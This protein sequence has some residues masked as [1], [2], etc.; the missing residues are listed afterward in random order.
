MDQT[1]PKSDSVF[2]IIPDNLVTNRRQARRR[3][4]KDS[5]VRVQSFRGALGMRRNSIVLLAILCWSLLGMSQT[6]DELVNKNIQAKGGMD[7]M[8]AIKTVRMT[9]KIEGP[10]LPPGRVSQENM[11]PKL[12]RETFSIQGMTAVQAYDGSTGWQIQPFGGKKD[13]MLM[14]DDDMR[15]LL[16]DADFDGP[17]VDYQEKGNRVEYLG[18]DVV[19]GDDALRLKVT[20]KNGDIVYY[21]LDP[22]TYLEIRKE[23]QEFIRG[24]IRENVIDLGSYKQAGGVMFPFS[25][26]SGPKNDPS[27]WQYVTYEKIEVNVPLET[28]EFAVP[29]SLK[30]EAPQKQETAK[31]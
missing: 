9:G 18:H 15:D 24:S 30:K 17:L 13:P 10:S 16:I 21:Y 14:G 28:S 6:A 26:A 7:K 3:D 25:V 12:V 27:S 4:V 23:T 22:D 2:V 1:S 5:F 31:N 11:R 29:A 19:D 20:L 8:K